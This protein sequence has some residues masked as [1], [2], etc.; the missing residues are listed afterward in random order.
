MPPTIEDAKSAAF[1]VDHK[2]SIILNQPVPGDD[3]TIWA[4]LKQHSRVLVYAFLA[5]CAA[6]LFGYDV[7]VQG[8]INALPVFSPVYL[9]SKGKAEGARKSLRRLG[10]G[11][12][13]DEQIAV[14]SA[15]AEQ[16]NDTDRDQVSYTECFRGSDARRT[17]IVALLNT[18]Q[19]FIGVS[20]VAN[21]TYFFIMAGMN[22]A[23]S[24]TINQVGVGCSMVC[25]LVS[26]VFIT[27][28]GRRTAILSS[29][30]LAGAIFIGMGIA[31]FFT[32]SS[33][34]LTFVGVALVMAAC[35]SNLGVGTAYPIASAEIPSTRLRAKTL[36]FG[37]LVNAL[38]T[39]AFSFCVP[40]MFNADA[41]NLGGKIGFVF[42]GFCAIGFV[43]S[44]LE[45]PETKDLT[46]SQIDDLFKQATPTRLFKKRT[47]ETR[48]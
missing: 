25:T 36:G 20:L 42:A 21:S 7:L 9:I 4:L 16:E 10:Y 17:R 30:V 3:M 38:A 48:A 32:R 19:Q 44:W 40:Y 39:W 14:I 8:A 2:E 24:L 31:G 45:I 35:C 12:A 6:F 41:G 28:V 37:F 26:W 22:P 11:A 15:T 34:A 33:Q 27:K 29:F 23:M 47:V 13:I 5:N 18:L 43:L 1:E 46:Y